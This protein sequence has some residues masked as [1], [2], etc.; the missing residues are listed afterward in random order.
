MSDMAEDDSK[1]EEKTGNLQNN[2]KANYRM[3]R[4]EG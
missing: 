3:H 1:R 2:K 4:H